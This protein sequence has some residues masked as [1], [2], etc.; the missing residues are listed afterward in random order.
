MHMG[1][2]N[3]YHQWLGL[4]ELEPVTL[5]EGNTPM[6]H[7]ATW[8]SHRI[9]LKLEGCNPTGSFKDRGMTVAVSQARCQGAEAVICAST[10]NT[11]ASAGAYAGRAGLKA[12]VVIPNNQVAL[13]KMI[14]ASAYGAT[15][16]AIEGNFDQAL[17]AVRDVAEQESWIALV[18]SVN[19]WRL[20]GQ[21]T[22]AYEILDG[23]GHAPSALVLPVGNAGN[24]S[25]YFHGFRRRNEGIPQ[26]F[27]I[28]AQGADPLVQEHEL[29]EVKTVASAIRI[30]RP[31]SAHLAKEAVKESRGQFRSVSDSQILRAQEELA[32]GGIFVEPASAAAYAGLKVLYQKR[33][34]PQ[35]DVVAILTGN[36]LKD[37]QTPAM[38]ASVEPQI[39]KSQYLTESIGQ[40]MNP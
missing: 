38:W 29:D 12:F 23:L 1:L 40:F 24:I 35:G 3:R 25:A 39:V 15:I 17:Q 20:R 6:V 18:N 9:W 36:G 26:L 32:H 7:W 8:E 2:I 19:P 34:L 16:L 27:G 22:G 37:T 31:A 28:Q 33:L 4:P 21:E 30:G 10:G 5:G 11:A 13:G 14:Q